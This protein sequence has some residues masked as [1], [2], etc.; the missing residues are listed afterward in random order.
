MTSVSFKLEGDKE[1]L[2]AFKKKAK[3]YPDAAGVALYKAGIRIHGPAVK[4]APRDTGYLRS[5]S[6]VSAPYQQG[7]STVSEVGFGTVYAARQHEETSWTHVDGEAKYL[8]KTVSEQ[9]GGMLA[10]LGADIQK[11][12]ESGQTFGAV[13]GVPTRPKAGPGKSKG[14]NKNGASR[15]KSQLANVRKRTGR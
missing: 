10:Q 8:S 9:L 15:F 11:A 3:E 1:L 2:E 14:V 13:G 12:V 6:Y 5:S 7:G 4:R